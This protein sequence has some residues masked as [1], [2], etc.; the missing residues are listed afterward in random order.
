MAETTEVIVG[1][2][3]R[4]GSLLERLERAERDRSVSWLL[5]SSWCAPGM[6]FWVALV[7][8]PGARGA[9]GQPVAGFG[10]ENVLERAVEIAERT[11]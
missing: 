3:Q 7:R 2:A 9:L 11:E 8:C 4:L 1:R 6:G 5:H 10:L